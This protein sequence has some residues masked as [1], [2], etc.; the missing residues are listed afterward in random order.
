MIEPGTGVLNCTSIKVVAMLLSLA[1]FL[2]MF[3][4][5]TVVMAYLIDG[6]QNPNQ[7]IG[8]A[9]IFGVLF[10]YWA[11]CVIALSDWISRT[12]SRGLLAPLVFVLW[13]GGATFVVCLFLGAPSTGEAFFENKGIQNYAKATGVVFVCYFLRNIFLS[14]RATSFGSSLAS[15]ADPHK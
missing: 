9:I 14:V 7:A 15:F 8:W 3:P 1:F 10:G 12:F 2:A 6:W 5:W 13:V 11:I 4:L